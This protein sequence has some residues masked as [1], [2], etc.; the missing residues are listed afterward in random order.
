MAYMGLKNQ[1]RIV[2]M[3]IVCVS[4]SVLLLGR[5]VYIQIIK[6]EHYTQ[7]AYDQQTRERTVEA[8]R[9]TV[10]DATGSKVLAQSVS[11]NVITVV[12]N[13]I[14]TEQ[15]ESVA[16]KLAEILELKKEDVL[17]KLSKKSSS[18][19]IASKVEEAIRIREVYIEMLQR[20]Q[21]SQEFPAASGDNR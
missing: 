9:G 7:M 20:E 11:V 8:K 16:T 2:M 18:E 12:P 13:S 14:E 1:K 10:Y 6:S 21:F 17:A 3:L 5:L 4:L 15:K 19:I